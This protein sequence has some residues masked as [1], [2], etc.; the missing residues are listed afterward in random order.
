M[1]IC[2]EGTHFLNET[3]SGQLHLNNLLAEKYGK[4]LSEITIHYSYRYTFKFNFTGESVTANSPRHHHR[5]HY[6]VQGLIHYT[7]LK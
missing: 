6:L 5:T 1:S 7:Y 2:P 3:F 4:L